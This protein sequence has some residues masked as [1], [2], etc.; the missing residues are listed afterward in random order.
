MLNRLPELRRKDRQ[1]SPEECEEIL[2]KAEYMTM[3]TADGDGIP[4][5]VPL[6]FVYFRGNVYFH[7]GKAD[8]HKIRNLRHNPYCS[9]A[10]T[11]DTQPVYTR[12]FTTYFESV[13]IFGKAEEITDAQEK[14]GALWALAEKYLPEHMDKAEKDIA[15]SLERTA[16][17]RI[18][19][20]KMTG[21]AK[22]PQ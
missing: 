7:T 22:R 15:A 18:T 12:N 6:S 1:I 13:I 17:Y 14:Y 4:Y 5:A 19:I 11:G 10:V 9:L 20:E 21:K 3:A 2:K 8:G 16:V